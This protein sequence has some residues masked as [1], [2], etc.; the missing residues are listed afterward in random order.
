M[1]LSLAQEKVRVAA[2]EYGWET[3]ELD[4]YDEHVSGENSVAV[5]YT[6]KGRVSRAEVYVTESEDMLADPIER[7]TPDK[8]TAVIEWLETFGTQEDS[9]EEETGLDVFHTEHVE[10]EAEA[11]AAE[12]ITAQLKEVVVGID[13]LAMRI[14]DKAEAVAAAAI[15][16][17]EIAPGPEKVDAAIK[18]AEKADD[19]YTLVRR[20][21]RENE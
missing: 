4:E 5:W 10:T 3:Y 15:S 6:A 14:N 2:A 17:T 21:Q 16:L 7:A 13:G 1:E 20:Q 12:E 18:L 8:I 9:G 19:L 11:V